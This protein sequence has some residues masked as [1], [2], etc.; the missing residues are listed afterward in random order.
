M[1]TN[2][3]SHK[4]SCVLDSLGKVQQ[5]RTC[6]ICSSES[7]YVTFFLQLISIISVAEPV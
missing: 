1:C 2:L 6:C 4:L 5:T 7:V 3:A